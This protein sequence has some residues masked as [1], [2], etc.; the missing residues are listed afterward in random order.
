MAQKTLLAL[1]GSR[2]ILPIV[3]AAHELGHRVVTCDYLPGN[4]AHAYADE[5][6][7]ASIVDEQAVLAVAKDVGADGIV[8]FAADPG[9]TAAAYV[10]EQLGMPFQGSY[11]AVCTL[12]SKDLFRAFLAENGFAT[13]VAQSFGSADEA[14]DAAEQIDYPVIVKPA[15][16]AGSKGVTR[17]DSPDALAPAVAF[18][19]GFSAGG[20]AIVETFIETAE[21]QLSAE[22]FTVAGR[23]EAMAFMD[24][25][26]DIGGP[27]PYAPAGNIFPSRAPMASQEQLVDEIQRLADLLALD[28]GIYNIEARIGIDGTPYIMEMSPRG[29][30][31]RLAE[32]IRAA[33][34]VDLIR[35]TVRAAVGEAPEVSQPQPD[36]FW[37]QK[38]L[39]S[40]TDGPFSEVWVDPEIRHDNLHE[41]NVWLS[42][43]DAVSA[44]THASFSFGSAF[45]QFPTREELD[46]VVADPDQFIRAQVR[47]TA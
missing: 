12:Q 40:R 45:L 23:F 11:E 26:F 34:G 2:L 43:G 25:L 9:V 13:P 44:F 27:N 18:A 31:N 6:R 5:Y 21:R 20:R 28:T 37:L 33:S 16:A 46:A 41:L 17:I 30:G 24:Q 1:G 47:P 29:G 38:M 3:E 19:L 35:A 32:F 15:D 7:N 36:G 4:F 10:A 8:S 42:E 22:G 39:F 14:A